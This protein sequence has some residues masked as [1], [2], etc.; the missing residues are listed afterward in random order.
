MLRPVADIGSAAISG[1]K[2]AW[3]GKQEEFV[4]PAANA[5]PILTMLRTADNEPVLGPLKRAAIN[6]VMKTACTI[7]SQRGN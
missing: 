1:E 6:K 3:F 2:V 4:T 7:A 5:T